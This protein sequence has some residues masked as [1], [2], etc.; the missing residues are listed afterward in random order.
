MR[1]PLTYRYPRTLNEAFGPGAEGAN[2]FEGSD[3]NHA[4]ADR[5]VLITC[6]LIVVLL[7]IGVARGWF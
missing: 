4:Q 1:D 2:T 6:A 5:P 3:P 7:L